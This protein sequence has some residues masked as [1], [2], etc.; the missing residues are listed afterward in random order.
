MTIFKIYDQSYGDRPFTA[1]LDWIKKYWNEDT[2]TNEKLV[3]N[4]H[5][6]M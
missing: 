3:I 2:I 6:V 4:S 5:C 1:I